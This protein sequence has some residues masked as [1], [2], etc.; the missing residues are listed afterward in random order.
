MH[1]IYVYTYAW[2][3]SCNRNGEDFGEVDRQKIE[4]DYLPGKEEHSEENDYSG[5]MG[6]SCLGEV[7]EE[8]LCSSVERRWR[9]SF[10]RR[11]TAR[12]LC[13][14]NSLETKIATRHHRE[15]SSASARVLCITSSFFHSRNAHGRICHW[16]SSWDDY[17]TSRA[18]NVPLA[19]V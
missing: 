2:T 13:R 5:R 10:A 17:A 4:G 11:P 9:M 16:A 14:L 6:R 19:R 3:C 1:K 8:V 18:A 12:M 15:H 7:K